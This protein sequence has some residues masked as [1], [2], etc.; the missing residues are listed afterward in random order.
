MAVST[1]AIRSVVMDDWACGLRCTIMTSAFD[2]GGRLLVMRAE[3]TA[4]THIPSYMQQVHIRCPKV[5][6]MTVF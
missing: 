6:R 1:D 3:K 2:C 5:L 4:F